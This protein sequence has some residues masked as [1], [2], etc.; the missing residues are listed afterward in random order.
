MEAFWNGRSEYDDPSATGGAGNAPGNHRQLRPHPLARAAAR[1]A[2]RRPHP[3]DDDYVYARTDLADLPGHRFVRKRNAVSQFS[4]RHPGFRVLPLDDA[5]ATDALAV[6]RGWLDFALAE[7]KDDAE[8][9]RY[10][11]AAITLALENR[12]ALELTAEVLHTGGRPA[13]MALA[14]PVNDET[15]DVHFE[16]ALPEFARDHAYAAVNQGLAA[17]LSPFAWLNR[18]EDLGD[19]G[20]RKAKLSYRPAAMIRRFRATQVR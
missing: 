7:G 18:E 14:S 17:M 15:A 2:R 1:G 5:T 10:E 4:R 16:K 8:G 20:L 19:E 11:L 3:G 12:A 6:A 13:A 9:V